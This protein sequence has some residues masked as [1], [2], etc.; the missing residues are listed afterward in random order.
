MRK[1]GQT[2]DPVQN[3]SGCSGTVCEK[4]DT[5]HISAYPVE[6]LEERIGYVFKNKELLINALTHSS[7][8][9]ELKGKKLHADD[10]ERLE[11]L[12]DSL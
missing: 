4:T 1:K 12:G 11:F 6:Q 3:C 7:Y 10:N 2:S 5:D 8:Y 9:N